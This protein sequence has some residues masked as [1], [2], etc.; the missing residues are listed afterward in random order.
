MTKKTST[1][2]F[3]EMISTREAARLLHVTT[4]TIKNY[5]YSGRL[6]GIK[7]PGGHHR[8]LRSD[9]IN[10]GFSEGSRK[11][12]RSA[13]NSYLFEQYVETIKAFM[14]ALDDRDI[15]KSGHS[16]RVAG[17]SSTIGQNLK[18][19]ESELRDL[20]LAALLHDVGKIGIS[21]N[22]LGKPGTLTDQE[23]FVVKEHAEI[24]EKLVGKVELLQPLALSIRQCHERFD[25]KGYPDGVAGTAIDLKARI[26]AVADTYDYLR[27]DLA[28]RRAL[29]HDDSIRELKKSAG[30][31]FDPQIVTMFCKIFSGARQEQQF[32][33]PSR[34]F[35]TLMQDST[36]H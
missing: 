12:E 9:L 36:R 25:G 19:A 1:V 14:N 27:S 26:I 3:K 4:Q 11:P 5:I 18:F 22:I 16:S 23:Y 34:V 35:E 20:K 13:A 21:E 32:Y 15:I 6:K 33:P 8:I 17:L 30:L 31:Q 29:S 10:L 28:Y 2:E 7:T 24:G